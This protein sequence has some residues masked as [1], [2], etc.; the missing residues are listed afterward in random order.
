MNSTIPFWLNKEDKFHKKVKR[1][2][3][4]FEKFSKSVLFY[5]TKFKDREETF[6][7]GIDVRIKFFLLVSLLI[8]IL[9]QKETTKILPFFIVSLFLNLFFYKVAKRFLGIVV[10]A[11]IFFLFTS[12]FTLTNIVIKGDILFPILEIKWA[13]FLLPPIVGITRE[14]I[15]VVYRMFLRNF[16]MLLFTLFFIE[17]TRV[18]DIALL[19]PQSF[20]VIFLIMVKNIKR[21]LILL[22]DYLLSQISKSPLPYRFK[23]K[24]RFTG[25]SIAKLYFDFKRSSEEIFFA[26]RSRGWEGRAILKKNFGTGEVCISCFILLIALTISFLL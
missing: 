7:F 8:V 3:L 1:S 15:F 16:S 17:N 13:N 2:D 21:F 6:L 18:S 20:R 9:F 19:M 11:F 10:F 4:Y 12:I 14:G 25:V 5:F 23:N 22:Y 24:K 26:L